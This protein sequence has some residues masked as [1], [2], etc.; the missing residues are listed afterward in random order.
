MQ[1]PNNAS[2]IRPVPYIEGLPVA[3][4]PESFSLETDEEENENCSP[5]PSM[6]N[7][8]DFDQESSSEPHLITQSELHDLVRDL[9]LTKNKAELLG[10]RLQQWNLLD[11]LDFQIS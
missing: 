9:E 8:P 11:Y 5:G 3:N 2:A 7:D 10:S 6:L 4:V 1:Y